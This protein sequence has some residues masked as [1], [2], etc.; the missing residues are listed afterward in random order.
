MK[1]F[2]VI[3][4]GCQSILVDGQNEDEATKKASAYLSDNSELRDWDAGWTEEIREDDD[5]SDFDIRIW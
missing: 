4:S 3:V 1:T 5:M 2:R